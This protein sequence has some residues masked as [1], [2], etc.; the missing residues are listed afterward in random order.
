MF[1]SIKSIAHAANISARSVSR[2]LVKL[3]ECGVVNWL[4]R[5]AEDWQDGRFVLRQETNAYGILPATQWRGYAP[6]A[7]SARAAIRH[8]GRSPPP[9][10]R[11]YP[12]LPREGAGLARHV[13]RVGGGRARPAGG[14]AGAAWPHSRHQRLKTPCFIGL[15]ACPCILPSFSFSYDLDPLKAPPEKRIAEPRERGLFCVRHLRPFGARAHRRASRVEERSY[16][17]KK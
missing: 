10:R 15:P 9:A 5:C 4:R 11:A 17:R 13:A 16:A 7:G 2:G 6:R 12:C 1:P 14:G 3:K 8:M